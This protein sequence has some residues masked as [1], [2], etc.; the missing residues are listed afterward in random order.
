[1]TTNAPCGRPSRA[2]LRVS[3]PRPLMTRVENYAKSVRTPMTVGIS[4]VG[5]PS[6]GNIRNEAEEHE[7]I[8][9]RCMRL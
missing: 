6:V 1:M 3:K 2:V 4:N 8:L 9:R 5:K 7:H